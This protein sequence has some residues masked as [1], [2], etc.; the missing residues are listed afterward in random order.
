PQSCGGP[1]HLSRRRRESGERTLPRD[2][3][4]YDE[5]LDLGGAFI[6]NKRFHIAEVAHNVEVERYAVAAQDV[7]SE[8]AHIARLD[9]AEILGQRRHRLSHL[10][11]VDQP[12]D[13]DAIG[14][15]SPHF[16]RDSCWPYFAAKS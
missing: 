5:G 2:M 15:E 16:V 13:T 7:A 4:A 6:G 3:T 11:L 9:G 10:A 14:H 12:P 1:E 8:A